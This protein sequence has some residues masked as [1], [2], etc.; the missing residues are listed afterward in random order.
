MKEVARGDNGANGPPDR[1]DLPGDELQDALHRV[2]M[3]AEQV[4]AAGYFRSGGGKVVS[5]V[6]QSL[7]DKSGELLTILLGEFGH[8]FFLPL[9]KRGAARA[10]DFR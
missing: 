2:P 7:S 9:R 1:A 10:A 3:L 4:F 8:C 6:E 5:F